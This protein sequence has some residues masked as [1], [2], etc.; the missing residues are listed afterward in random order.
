MAKTVKNRFYIRINRKRSYSK[1]SDFV[2]DFKE[3]YFHF[4][5]I[6]VLY[7]S[8]NPK[9]SYYYK[10]IREVEDYNYMNNMNN[11][12]YRRRGQRMGYGPEAEYY[13]YSFDPIDYFRPHHEPH[14][15]DYYGPNENNDSDEA[16]GGVM[17]TVFLRKSDILRY[18]STLPGF[19]EKL[20]AERKAPYTAP[21]K[22]ESLQLKGLEGSIQQ[23]EAKT[24]RTIP[25]NVQNVIESYMMRRRPP[26]QYFEQRNNIYRI[27]PNL[28][29]TEQGYMPKN[30][31]A[32]DT[33]LFKE[34]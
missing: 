27:S 20:A 15:Y 25:R 21:A 2:D 18:I 16:A 12:N 34:K 6:E 28:F 31:K 17:E 11:Y 22:L 4:N 23:F 24:G 3:R 14:Y 33:S 7:L 32:I 1:L 13:I 9:Q 30:L 29:T 19:A 5:L 26:P 10:V 8:E